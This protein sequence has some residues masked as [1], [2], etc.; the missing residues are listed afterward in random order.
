MAS[1]P[2]GIRFTALGLAC[3]TV[4]G[5]GNS[6]VVAVSG[7]LKYKGK[8]VTNAY[9]HF[10]PEKG[11]PSMG[12]TDA[13]GRF[14]LTYDPQIKGAQRGKH[15]VFVEHNPGA[16]QSKPGAIPG[17]PVAVDPSMKVFFDK[18]GG[19]NSKVEVTIDK[20]IDD[21]KLDWD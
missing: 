19:T 15:R 16:E 20:A 9:V 10:V 14:T 17:M 18:Y 2:I 21:L 11:R 13:E 1:L 4:A 5:C 7:H 3:L 6:D 12:T 8:P